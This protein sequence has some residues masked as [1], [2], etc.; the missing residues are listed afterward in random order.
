MLT[1]EELRSLRFRAIMYDEDAGGLVS[2]NPAHELLTALKARKLKAIDA[3][4]KE[5]P[6][7]FWDGR[8]LDLRTWP[9]VRFRREDMVQLW[10]A[11]GEC[12]KEPPSD[13]GP[14][15]AQDLATVEPEP[16]SEAAGV[17][18]E[19]RTWRA[20]RNERFTQR[21]RLL[22]EW[23]NFAE[24]ADWC[25][26]E[27]GSIIPDEPKGAV[28]LD[29]LANDLLAGEFEESGRSRVLYLHPWSTKARMTRDWLKDARQHD[30]DGD[31]GR[32]E[33]LAHCWLS[34][35]MFERWLV[36]HRLPE[37]PAH[38]QPQKT[39]LTR[40]PVAETAG[41]EKVAIS[42]LATYLKANPEVSRV[43]AAE[44][45]RTEGFK[46]SGRGFQFR[47]WPEARKRAGLEVKA[48]PGRK[49]K[50]SR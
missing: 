42:A 46:L 39:R 18:E 10:P 37:S 28:A 26:K 22:R 47:V 16:K 49:P 5:L 3:E 40:Q 4:H 23:I 50:S 45:C 8:S 20:N 2:K 21:Q 13:S 9:A 7:E 24:I 17:R 36:K 34:R 12:P 31:H 6:A 35:R 38:F 27:D 30:L 15:S 19:A 32:S 29:T 11:K 41:G 44:W 43:D 1:P 33:Y 48:P 14:E 25:S